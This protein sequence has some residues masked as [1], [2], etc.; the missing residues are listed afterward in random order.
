MSHDALTASQAREPQVP[1]PFEAFLP[2]AHTGHSLSGH[3][4]TECRQRPRKVGMA[5]PSSRWRKP[6]LRE[7]K[8]LAQG[9]ITRTQWS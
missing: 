3:C 6:R 9:H 1:P 4:F 5:A 2:C 7:M 8:Q